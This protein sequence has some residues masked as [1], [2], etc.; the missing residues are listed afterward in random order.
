MASYSATR[1]GRSQ[2]EAGSR[3]A[4]GW[5]ARG[6]HRR[7]PA[8]SRP[9]APRP[10][11]LLLQ[12]PAAAVPN[13]PLLPSALTGT[14]SHAPATLLPGCLAQSKKGQVLA[15]GRAREGGIEVEGK[16]KLLGFTAFEAVAGSGYHRPALHTH[17]IAGRNLQE[18][19]L[20]AAGVEA[21]GGGPGVGGRTRHA[22]QAE[23]EAAVVQ[24]LE[25]DNDD[26]CHICG[27]GVSLQF[28]WVAW[29]RA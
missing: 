29:G 2:R 4:V 13:R 16:A 26:L 15:L 6:M 22:Q 14:F 18:L 25:D 10:Q 27:L 8:A 24:L 23:Q 1:C 28:A 5:Q 12:P 17:T 11:L 19:Q 3:R 20:Q 9:A 7:H 21:S